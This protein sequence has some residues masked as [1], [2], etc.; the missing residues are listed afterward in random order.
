MLMTNLNTREQFLICIVIL[1]ASGFLLY[2][3]VISPELKHMSAAH[4]YLNSQQDLLRIKTEEAQYRSMLNDK[5]QQLETSI[6][7]T[8]GLMFDRDEAMGFLKLL[9]QLISQTGS[10]LIT[11]EPRDMELLSSDGAATQRTKQEQRES[12]M[13]AE[14]AHMRMPVQIA[15][16]AKY[17]GIIRFFEQLEELKKLATVSQ[18]NIATEANAP[19][20]V[21]VQ[22]TLNLYVYKHQEI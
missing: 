17:S 9:L 14:T 21:Y 7:E 8:K 22:L 1:L 2:R 20:E 10:V 15:V 16:R 4:Y 6:A 13:Q 3:F 18:I 11:M 12:E 5:V 19:A